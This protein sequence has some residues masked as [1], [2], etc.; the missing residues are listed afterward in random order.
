MMKRNILQLN[1]SLSVELFINQFDGTTSLHWSSPPQKS[2]LP[3][4]REM[5]VPWAGKILADW[6]LETG[7]TP[8][9]IDPVQII[10]AYDE[11]AIS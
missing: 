2:D 9:E 4:L 3:I 10:G 8:P 11:N 5:F 1:D 6:A 7:I